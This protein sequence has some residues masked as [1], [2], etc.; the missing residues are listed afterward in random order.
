M[1][2]VLSLSFSG[3]GVIVS[4]LP[5]QIG[6]PN[7]T[8]KHKQL[9]KKATL[10]SALIFPGA[11]L[12]LLGKRMLACAFIISSAITLVFLFVGIWAIAQNLADQ[13]VAEMAASASFSFNITELMQQIRTQLH[14]R[15]ELALS[16]WLFV[17]LWLSSTLVTYLIARAQTNNNKQ[18]H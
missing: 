1:N 11:G 8:M 6:S 15:P 7:I 17:A 10:Y 16:K 3:P 2:T 9:R 12:W 13:L 5:D 14:A 18:Q 4:L